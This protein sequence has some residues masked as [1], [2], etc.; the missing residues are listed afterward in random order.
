M[1]VM[2]STTDGDALI[3][4]ETVAAGE[5]PLNWKSQDAEIDERIKAREKTVYHPGGTAAMGKVVDTSLR[6]Y[7]VEGLRV[8]DI[9]VLPLPIS[10]RYQACTYAL[11]EQ[12]AG[13]IE[14]DL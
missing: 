8:V 4:T 10:G 9:S 11:A 13:I 1:E 3:E 7:G 6:V 12:A 2:L 14:A 5:K